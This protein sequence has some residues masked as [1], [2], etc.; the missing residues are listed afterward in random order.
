MPEKRMGVTYSY[1]AFY[2]KVQ[3]LSH[4]AIKSQD[5]WLNH[6]IKSENPIFI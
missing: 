6:E 3:N 5:S 2:D 1:S 4:F